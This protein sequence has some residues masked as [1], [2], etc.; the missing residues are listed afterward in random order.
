MSL[1]DT[2]DQPK[3]AF[4]PQDPQFNPDS[5]QIWIF[6]RPLP[7]SAFHPYEIG[8]WVPASAES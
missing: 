5:A 7:N 1:R 3:A 8:K 4:Q 2:A 6:L